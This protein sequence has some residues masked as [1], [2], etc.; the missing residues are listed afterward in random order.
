[1][2]SEFEEPEHLGH[3]K[4]VQAVAGERTQCNQDQ[5]QRF[6]TLANQDDVTLVT[7]SGRAKEFNRRLIAPG[8]RIGL[9]NRLQ[10]SLPI[11][12]RQ[13]QF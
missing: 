1:M 2:G 9:A 3:E 8:R 11:G 10:G 6:G 7:A 13:W 12:G 4:F 5:K